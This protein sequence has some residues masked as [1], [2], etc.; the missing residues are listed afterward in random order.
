M[1]TALGSLNPFVYARPL[2]PQEAISRDED[3]SHL[4]TL[5]E[6][7]HNATLVAPRRY[8]KT[9]LLKQLVDAGERQ[10]DMVAVL[11]DFSDVLSE[12]DVAARLEHG[13]RILKGPI[14]RF[15]ASHLQ[16]VGIGTPAGGL[17]LQR[18]P[19]PEPI[20]VIHE[21]L[22]LPAKLHTREGRRVMVV[23]DEFQALVALGGMDGVFRSHLQHH[24]DV[25]SYVFSGS[26][27]SLLRALF[28]DR[29]RPLF[30]QAELS[31]LDRL[32]ND[33]A[34]AFVAARFAEAGKQAEPA[35]WPLVFAADGHPQRLM[36]LAHRLWDLTPSRA[37]ADVA[38][39][40]RAYEA[41]M[42]Q[43][44]AE[45]RGLWDSLSANERRVLLGVASGLSPTESETVALTGL[46][47]RSS[48]QRAVEA[49]LGRGV[50]ERGDAG[51]VRI[52]DPLLERW[53]RRRGGARPIAYVLPAGGRWLVTDGPSLAF[54][55][56]RHDSL[57][58]AERAAQQIVSKRAGGDV[59]VL[60]TDDPNDLPEWAIT[61]ADWRHGSP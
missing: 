15:V 23:F 1:G 30:G 22:E 10:A 42:R 29:A 16:S 45:M 14:A 61:L 37:A 32:P 52:V 56:S 20:A 54:E 5:A 58:A 13:Y 41:T 43:V 46:R 35:L 48:A 60:D 18:S 47:S 8:G 11:V 17:V 24:G 2:A 50:L 55:H 38:L 21:L 26:E 31:R 19:R 27:P 36:L 53:A 3:V 39:L 34:G 6:G 57:D 59:I 4:L 25:A 51:G 49:L 12:A 40:G 9:S 33:R 44:D 28:E 7:G